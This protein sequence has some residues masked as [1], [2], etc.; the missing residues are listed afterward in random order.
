MDFVEVEGKT[1]E[2]AV[3]K[4]SESLNADEKD[5]DI[6]VTEVDTKGILGLLGSKKVRIVAR[7]RNSPEEYG[8]QFLTELASFYGVT[9]RVDVTKQGERILFAIESGD[10][11]ALVGED[12]EVLDAIQHLVKLAIA[13]RYKQSLKLL[14]D[15]NDYREQRKKTIILMAKRLADKVRKEGRPVKTK[16]LNPYERRLIHTLFKNNNRITTHSEGEGHT[17]KVIISPSSPAHARR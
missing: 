8:K 4:A 16:P 14:V 11:D 7:I 3:R 1:Y 6:E 15:V 9:V 12:G 10:G 13:K 2:E 17:K 5:L